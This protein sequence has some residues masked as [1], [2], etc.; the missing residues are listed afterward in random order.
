MSATNYTSDL[1][2]DECIRQLLRHTGRGGWTPWAE[3]TI[4]AKIRGDHFTL[5]AWGPANLRNSFAP[6]FYGRLEEDKGKTHICGRYRMHPI[7]EAFL[8]VWFGGLVVM[9]ALILFLPPSAWGAGRSPS[10]FAVVGPVGMMVLGFGMV[11]FGRWLA[12][13]QAESLRSFLARELKA[14]PPVENSPNTLLQPSAI[15]RM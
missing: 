8:A 10:G 13:G 11:R 9:A 2:K 12:R 15:K 3:G 5:F 7:L 14:Q 6:R 1:T 4:A